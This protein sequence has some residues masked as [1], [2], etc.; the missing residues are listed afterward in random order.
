MAGTTIGVKTIS[1]DT[2]TINLSVTPEIESRKLYLRDLLTKHNY[3]IID[4]AEYTIFGS[5]ISTTNRFKIIDPS[6]LITDN[7]E[8]ILINIYVQNNVITIEN[9]TKED[10]IAIVY[11]M[12]GRMMANKEVKSKDISDFSNISQSQAGVYI[13]KVFNNAQSIIKTDKIILK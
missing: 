4:N 7:N 13:V 2:Y 11:D 8:G 12:S 5:K 10:C 6:I 1:N 3:P 9:Q